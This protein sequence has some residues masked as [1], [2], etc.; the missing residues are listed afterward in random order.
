MVFPEILEPYGPNVATTEGK[1]YNFHVR[2][3]APPFSDSSGANDLVWSEAASQT[4]Q[5]MDSWTREGPTRDL[6]LDINRLTLGVISYTGFGVKLNFAEG[7]S[8]SK[9]VPKGFNLSLLH[10]LH[11]VVTYMVRILVVPK[12][13]MRISPMAHIALAHT[14]LERY[15]RAMI[16]SEKKKLEKD[17]EHQIGVAKGNLLISVLQASAKEGISLGQGRKH[18]FSEDEVLGNLFLYLLAGY[19]TTANAITYGLITLALRQDL[20]EKVITEI[21]DIYRGAHEGGRKDL[22]YSDD[23]EKLEYTFGFMYETFRLYPG[24]TLITK[25][26]LKP[27]KVHIYPEDEESR[28]Y[29]L[30][31]Q[32]RVYLN[33]NAVHYHDRY[34]PEPLQI[35]PERWMSDVSIRGP[36]TQTPNKKVD[37]SDRARQV[38]GRL[39]TFSGGARACLGRK[40]AQSEYMSVLSTLLREYRV[41]LGTGLNP[42]TVK[43]ELDNLASGGVTLS[44]LRYVPLALE[45]RA[46]R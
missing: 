5:L 40:F 43:R 27:A 3:T 20:Q 28:Q 7:I 22:N 46:D 29:V 4:R 17:H 18:A 44:P 37:A 19:E 14:E 38:R 41:V 31:A 2:I 34:W 25:V 12:W 1:E 42:A 8:D 24:V 30:P 11:T 26:N 21:D 23:F 35:K 10:A 39:M 32:C 45:K 33:V 13:L 15:M 36:E 16:R 6:S 9:I